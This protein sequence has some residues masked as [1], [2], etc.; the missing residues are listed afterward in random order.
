VSTIDTG[1]R[2]VDLGDRRVLDVGGREYSTVYSERLIRLLIARKGVART[3]PY[4]GFKE[5]RGPHFLGPL[6]RYLRQRGARGLRVLEVG[7]SFGHLTEYLCEQPEVAELY[8]FDTDREFV[9]MTRI[10]VHELGLGPVREV[11]C[12]TNPETR[13]LPYTDR[14]FDLVL[15]IGVVEHLPAAGRAAHVDEWYRVLAPGGHIAVLDTPNR[16][17]P[18]ETHSVGLPL[19]Q[20]L[21]PSLAWRY[22]R[23]FRP[24]RYGAI[25]LPEFLADGTGWRNASFRQCLPSTGM[26]GL[27]DVTE[28]IGY[29]SVFFRRTARSRIRRAMLPVFALGG[30]ALRAVGKSPSLC[31]PYLNLVFRRKG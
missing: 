19:V 28:E 30:T 3:P 9:E 23:T 2:I 1:Y 26:A 10:K 4:F 25:P 6:F 24:S 31:L 17:F 27:E 22:A 29:G 11:R 8:A 5:S 7:C 15:A 20:W 21:S 13:A 14:S 16:A 18:L 12:F